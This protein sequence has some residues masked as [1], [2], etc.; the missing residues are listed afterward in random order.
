MPGLQG[1][2]TVLG[3][4]IT[5]DYMWI[6]AKIRSF[7]ITDVP[8]A[9]V[10]AEFDAYVAACGNI[11]NAGIYRATGVGKIKFTTK[12]AAVIL[13]E[14]HD[15]NSTIDAYYETIIGGLPKTK[16]IRVPAPGAE[17]FTNGVIA[18]NALAQITAWTGATLTI[19]N[20]GKV[21]GDDGFYTYSGSYHSDATPAEK[22]RYIPG[23][24]ADDIV[25]PADGS[26]AEGPGDNP[27]A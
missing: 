5:I 14:A 22:N 4:N 10:E 18:N 26:D 19:L 17:L 23:F 15:I 1:T 11:T 25:E 27:A 21:A 12:A 24:E 6:S 3:Q 9:V 2:P 8:A 16:V 7:G 20:K 13:D